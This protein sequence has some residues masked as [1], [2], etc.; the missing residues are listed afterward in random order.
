MKIGY[1]RHEATSLG[2]FPSS[3]S[4]NICTRLRALLVDKC[5]LAIL[6]RRQIHKALSF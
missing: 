6:H 3:V 1:L 2:T 5:K 4:G